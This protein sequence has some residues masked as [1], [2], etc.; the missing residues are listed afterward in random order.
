MR[1]N[2][3]KLATLALSGMMV[4]SMAVPAFAFPANELTIPF[5]KKLY[6]D[7]ETLAPQTA[8]DFEIT[9]ATANGKW[10]YQV[11]QGAVTKEEEVNTVPGPAG[12]VIVA[13]KATFAPTVAPNLKFMK[14]M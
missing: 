14:R 3:N 2:L 4:M 10:K 13:E 5:T 6:V 12:G 7:G 11:K 1:K 8:F 9:P